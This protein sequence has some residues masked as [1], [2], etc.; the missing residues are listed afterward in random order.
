MK[1]AIRQILSVVG[2]LFLSASGVSA[3]NGTAPA[4]D[5]PF[6]TQY[7]LGVNYMPEWQLNNP[8]LDGGSSGGGFASNFGLSFEVRFTPHSGLET[9]FYCR[10]VKFPAHT[11]HEPW[12]PSITYPA[13]Y[14]RYFSIPVLYKFYSRIVN[15]GA[16]ITCDFMFDNPD[17]SRHDRNRVGILLKVSK[18]IR[19]YKGLFLEPEF[20]YNPFWAEHMGDRFWMGFQIGLKYRF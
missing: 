7:I 20:H 12:E 14:Q 19:L 9:G 4:E 5:N 1:K 17:D 15:V 10:N 3:Q 2:I 11:S 16:G 6:K 18:D 13:T 8:Q